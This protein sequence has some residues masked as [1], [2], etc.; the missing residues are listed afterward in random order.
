MFGISPL[1]RI[2][3]IPGSGENEMCSSY[4]RLSLQARLV[5]VVGRVNHD[6]SLFRLSL[7]LCPHS[8]CN[9]ELISIQY[10]NMFPHTMKKTFMI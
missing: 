4:E 1:R 8:G 9:V 5:R 7:D 10:F 6:C 3:C 2:V